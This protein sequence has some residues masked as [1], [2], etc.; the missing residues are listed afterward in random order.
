MSPRERSKRYRQRLKSDPIKYE[1]YKMRERERSKRKAE[2]S[3]IDKT[4]RKKELQRTKWR[5]TKRRYRQSM[6]ELKDRFEKDDMFFKP[7][8]GF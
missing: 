6:K 7:Q 8:S 4:P 1:E 3:E 5:E 2:I